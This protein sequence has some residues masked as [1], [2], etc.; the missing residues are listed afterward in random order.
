MLVGIGQVLLGLTLL[1]GDILLSLMIM[2]SIPFMIPIVIIF[3]I[4]ACKY[5]LY[6]WNQLQKQKMLDSYI[7]NQKND[8]KSAKKELEKLNRILDKN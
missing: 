4:V 1:S 6:K 5:A 7:K 8:I 3:N 2:V